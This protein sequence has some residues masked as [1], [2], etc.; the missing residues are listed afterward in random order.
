MAPAF[1]L[2]SPPT[3]KEWDLRGSVVVGARNFALL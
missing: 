3:V 2:S 1:I